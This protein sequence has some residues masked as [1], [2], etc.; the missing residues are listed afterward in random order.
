MSVLGRLFG[1]AS[2]MSVEETIVEFG[3]FLI[4][5][6]TIDVAYEFIRDTIIITSHRIIVIDVKGITGKRKIIKSIKFDAITAFSIETD[7]LLTASVK[8]KIWT[9]NEMLRFKLSSDTDCAK[10]LKDLTKHLF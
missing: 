2:A 9:N 1:I 4:D 5:D 10:L 3:N 6:E 7:S 8:L